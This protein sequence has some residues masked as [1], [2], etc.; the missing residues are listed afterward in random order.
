MKQGLGNNV[1]NW[2]ICNWGSLRGV[3][4][5]CGLLLTHNY[6]PA[7]KG[8]FFFKCRLI[9]TTELSRYELNGQDTIKQL[10]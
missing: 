8:N 2:I 10:T 4:L 1:H 7:S 9:H 5:L 6:I 3:D